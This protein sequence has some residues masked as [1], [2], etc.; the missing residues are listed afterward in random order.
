MVAEACDTLIREKHPASPPEWPKDTGTPAQVD[1]SW[2]GETE[3]LQEPPPPRR[4]MASTPRT[5]KGGWHS[6][7]SPSPVVRTERPSALHAHPPETE[8]SGSNGSA[9]WEEKQA[10][11]KERRNPVVQPTSGHEKDRE[12]EGRL[13]PEQEQAMGTEPL[14]DLG[15]AIL[16]GLDISSLPH[17]VT[18]PR[19][20]VPWSG[21]RGLRPEWSRPPLSGDSG[22]PRLWRSSW[23]AGTM[24]GTATGTAR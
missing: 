23:V 11:R 3:I 12:D 15:L 10:W 16:N 13:R 5:E 14:A 6:A 17:S 22:R 20:Q 1:Q 2:K 24:R 4:K 18:C 8:E 19:E 7:W 9:G 21:F